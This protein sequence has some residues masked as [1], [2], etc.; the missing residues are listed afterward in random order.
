M[1]KSKN[2]CRLTFTL[3]ALSTFVTPERAIGAPIMAPLSLKSEEVPRAPRWLLGQGLVPKGQSVA[4]LMAAAGKARLDG[5]Y[6]TCLKKIAEVWGRAKTVQPWLLT[7]EIECAS[8]PKTP[9]A[10]QL[11]RVLEKARKNPEWF[12]KGAQVSILRENFF[13]ASLVAI[14][15]DMKRNRARAAATGENLMEFLNWADKKQRARYWRLMGELMFLNQ[16]NQEAYELLRRSLNE[17]D[18]DETRAVFSTVE[19]A[20]GLDKLNLDAKNNAARSLQSTNQLSVEASEKEMQLVARVTEALKTGDLLTAVRDAVELIETFPGGTRA[21]WAADRAF[22]AYMRVAEKNDPKLERTRSRMIKEMSR[23]DSDRL[24]A[25]ARSLYS[26]GQWDDALTLSRRALDTL[27]GERSTGVL[28]LAAK[29]AVATDRFDLALEY[30]ER[31]SLQH[32]GTSTAREALL[33]AALVRFRIGKYAQATADLERVLAIPEAEETWGLTARYWLWRSLQKQKSPRA[34]QVADEL[35]Q[36][37]PF[38]YYGL[39][40]RMERSS[41][42]LE[43]RQPPAPLTTKLW[44]TSVERK[45]FERAKLLLEAGWLDEAQVELRQMP[46]PQKAEDKAMWS[47]LWAAAGNYV[48]ASRLANEAWDEKFEFRRPPFVDASFPKEFT[49]DIEQYASARNLDRDLVR[50]LI[51]QESGFN[52]KAVSS[53]NAM[54]LMQLIPPTAKEVAQDLKLGSLAIPDD[55]FSAPRNIQLGTYYL[56]RM[57]N[58]YGG[59]VPLALAA[60]NAGPTRLDRWL[61]GRPSLKDVAQTHSSRPEDELWFDEI[62]YL[63]TSIYVK[64]ILRNLLIYKMLDLGRVEVSDPIWAFDKAKNQGTSSTSR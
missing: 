39:R 37:F 6:D 10:A 24:V 61:K 43:W 51:K 29:C 64:S 56:S 18:T 3:L 55:L 28:D 31:L 42:T 60:Y 63:E 15:A 47:L 4:A 32:A 59:H 33:R 16:K 7:A 45:A 30:F 54:G 36:K 22:E 21:K 52:L 38:S 49:S 17:A 27:S 57:I 13:S 1:M 50:G 11:H 12:I 25:W 34:D 14:E 62:P 41:S 58:R 8:K 20:I 40:A 5:Q 53:A 35:M 44:L 46:S 2:F 23:V 48:N 19:K 26:R 9:N